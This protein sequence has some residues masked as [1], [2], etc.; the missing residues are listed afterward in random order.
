MAP[1][2]L[3]WLFLYIPTS[4][5]IK[6]A[7]RPLV[8]L[9]TSYKL[10]PSRIQTH[11]G[12][13]VWDIIVDCSI[14]RFVGAL[15]LRRNSELHARLAIRLCYYSLASTFITTRKT[16][17]P[18]STTSQRT[19]LELLRNSVDN[20]VR[21]VTENESVHRSVA[22]CT[23]PL[24]KLIVTHVSLQSLFVWNLNA[25][26]RLNIARTGNPSKCCQLK[27]LQGTSVFSS[28]VIS[29]TSKGQ[30]PELFNTQLR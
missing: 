28:H 8:R 16:L 10:I 30:L 20:A 6:V 22:G 11:A 14:D 24:D 21:S 18:H 4:K 15:L 27:L 7:R 23:D 12:W 5:Y 1:E 29:R 9:Q 19:E 25:N 3:I 13:E 2:L 26:Y 17:I